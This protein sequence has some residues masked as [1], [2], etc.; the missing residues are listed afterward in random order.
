[1]PANKDKVPVYSYVRPELRQLLAEIAN[2]SG[3]KTITA[4]IEEACE[5]LVITSVENGLLTS[6]KA[7][8]EV[9]YQK[10]EYL[11]RVESQLKQMA[12]RV[13]TTP[14]EEG[15]EE[16]T[17]L[18]V[19]NGFSAEDVVSWMDNVADIT[20]FADPG[21]TLGPSE[22]FL[23]DLFIDQNPGKLI[24]V[25]DVKN[26]AAE[27]NLRW[28]MVEKARLNFPNKAIK[29][30]RTGKCNSWFFDPDSVN[31]SH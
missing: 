23:I 6:P 8:V 5:L 12:I 30:K 13:K 17:D 25:Q 7:R 27:K 22:M 20:E 26:L 24:K 1:M 29:S 15:L 3:G 21:Q 14:T 28:S 11:K 4:V 9:A 16:L 19:E 18:A 31:G 10:M 2:K